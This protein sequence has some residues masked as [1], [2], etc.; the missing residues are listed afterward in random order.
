VKS[1][2]WIVSMGLLASCSAVPRMRPASPPEAS[3]LLDRCRAR[4]PAGAWQVVHTIEFRLPFGKRSALL[5][6]V[7]GD[8]SRGFLRLVAMAPE[9]MTLLDVTSVR[10]VMKI[11]S[12]VPPFTRRSLVEG[13]VRDVR[14]MLFVPAGRARAG[15]LSGGAAA[16]RWRLA[17]GATVDVLLGVGKGQGQGKGKGR[18]WA[19]RRYDPAGRLTRSVRCEGRGRSG[20][21][22]RVILRAHETVGYSLD[23]RLLRVSGPGVSPR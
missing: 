8:S 15:R 22:G 1:A 3:R 4:F 14:L 13:M 21:A 17:D 5:G 20:F 23:L 16:C 9:G 12:A 11:H 6:V 10:G 18:S 2:A 7:T 19:L